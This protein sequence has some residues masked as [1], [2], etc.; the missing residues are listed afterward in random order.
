MNANQ[1]A[2]ENEH[3]ARFIKAN[4]NWRKRVSYEARY[5][6]YDY[7]SDILF[8]RFGNPSFVIMTYMDHDDDEFQW[9]FEESNLQIVAIEVMPFRKR[10]ASR[11]PKLQAAYDAMRR[12][13]A[14]ATGKSTFRLRQT[15]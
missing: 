2:A 10:Y 11:Y 13:W 1:I 14:R 15:T 7:E 3:V 6:H 8:V 4:P 12:D 5:I 9:G